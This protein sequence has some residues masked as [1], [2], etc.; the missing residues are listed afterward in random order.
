MGSR[1]YN[2]TNEKILCIKFIYRFTGWLWGDVR[3]QYHDGG[4]FF[5]SKIM[6]SN[7]IL[8]CKLR[9]RFVFRLYFEAKLVSS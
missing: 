1:G 8:V 9:N 6:D 3:A 2:N 4:S 7:L 5:S